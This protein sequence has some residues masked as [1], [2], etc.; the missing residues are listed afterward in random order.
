MALHHSRP[1]RKRT[2]G[3]NTP[4]SQ[5]HAPTWRETN[6]IKSHPSLSERLRRT[7]ISIQWWLHFLQRDLWRT[8]PD[9]NPKGI[10]GGVVRLLRIIAA[11][12]QGFFDLRLDIKASALTYSTTLSIVPLLAVVIGVAK[13]FGFQQTIYDFLKT[14]LPSHTEQLEQ[15]FQYVE[16]YLSQVHGGMFIGFGL[17]FLL[18]TVFGLLVSIEDTFNEIW[19]VKR[20]RPWIRRLSDYL[21]MLLIMPILMVASSGVSLMLATIRN[22][23]MQEYALFTPLIEQWLS[24][25]PFILSSLV[26]MLM[27]L[28]LPG[29]RVRF[30]PALIAGG[31]AGISFQMFQTLYMNGVL[32]ISRYNAIYGGVAAF[33]LLL[34]WMQLTWLITLFCVRLS[35]SIQNADSFVYYKESRHMSTRYRDFFAVVLMSYIA[36]R[37]ARGL[38]A[39]PYSSET[40]TEESRLPLSVV[41]QTLSLLTESG[42]LV[43][44]PYGKRGKSRHYMPA[45]D[46]RKIS[47][48]YLLALID[49]QGNESFSFYRQRFVH[50]WQFVGQARELYQEPPLADTLLC[51][52]EL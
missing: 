2:P 28:V 41:E 33:P 51:D 21:A 17:L 11:S 24:V 32:W 22:S 12:V 31:L 5:G 30:L 1:S 9:F 52:V 10:R 40:L 25:V 43:E 29:V 35:F 49:R 39:E 50:P 7:Q 23:F 4:E 38:P 34:L 18:Y 36:R 14:S 6:T 45:T 47:V 46:L 8:T 19:E 48:G 42:I 27:F 26:F 44:V 37:F 16:N 15:S 20:S 13:G 3:E